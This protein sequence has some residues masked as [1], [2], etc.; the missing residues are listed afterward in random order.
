MADHLTDTV[1]VAG[2]VA[3]Q[4]PSGTIALIACLVRDGSLPPQG[5]C[6]V[7]GL[8]TDEIVW[9]H[10]ECERQ[11]PLPPRVV[12][13]RHPF[14]GRLS[15]L[16]IRRDALSIEESRFSRELLPIDVPLRLHHDCW[17]ERPWGHGAR[18]V[19]MLLQ[20]V[21]VYARLLAEYPVT[22]IEA[23]EPVEE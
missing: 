22:R 8:A 20:V 9:V 7:C 21:P 5:A 3:D 11:V 18:S 23:I 14:F 12:P 15:G 4:Q 1:P 6:A 19:R 10:L 2:P 13:L 16:F 17:R